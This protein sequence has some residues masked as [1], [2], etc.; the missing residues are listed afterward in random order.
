MPQVSEDCTVILDGHGYFLKPGSYREE[1]PKLVEV[2]P[3][4][5]AGPP[6]VDYGSGKQVWHFTVLAQSAQLN[7]DG[8][9]NP[10][11][12]ATY[13]VNLRRSYAQAGPLAY[14]D[15]YGVTHAVRFVTLQERVPE[16]AG[17]WHT[18]LWELDVTLVEA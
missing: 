6:V 16:A 7:R 4:A 2:A 1:L 5:A 17:R 12:A 8:T 3:E 9:V 15:P 13:R 11:P 10:T 18:A 14:V